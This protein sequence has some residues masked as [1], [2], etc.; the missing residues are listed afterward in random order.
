MG[1]RRPW[2][3]SVDVGPST[4]T[5]GDTVDFEVHV[6]NTGSESMEITYVG[7]HF[8]WMD[9]GY[10]YSSG[11]VSDDNPYVLG[12]GDSA[13]FYINGVPIPKGITTNTYHAAEVLITAADPGI[14]NEWGSPYSNTYSGSVFVEESTSSGG[15]NGGGSSGT[16]SSPES[17]DWLIPLAIFIVI[18]I[19]IIAVIALVMTSK[20]K[21]HPPPYQ[22]VPPPSIGMSNQ[23][24][25]ST[26]K[27]CP[28]CGREIPADAKICPYCGNKVG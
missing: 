10:Y 7:I 19:V 12:S 21:N 13:I 1:T 24:I 16:T 2:D 5:S 23:E 25:Q 8:D 20:K 11:D 3:A 4:V 6:T 28:Y 9:Q 22:P 14:I 15:S 17:P 18:L 26:T 27:I